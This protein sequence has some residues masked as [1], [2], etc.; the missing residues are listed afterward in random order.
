MHELPRWD[1]Y[2]YLFKKIEYT[3]DQDWV[4][5]TNRCYQQGM[6]TYKESWAN[7]GIWA[8]IFSKM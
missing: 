2:Q 8:D 4:L 7:Y 1:V 5:R 3:Q 6:I